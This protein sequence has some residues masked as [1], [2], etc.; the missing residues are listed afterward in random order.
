MTTPWSFSFDSLGTRS[1]PRRSANR[2]TSISWHDFQRLRWLVSSVDAVLF[3]NVHSKFTA[4]ALG[5]NAGRDAFHFVFKRRYRYILRDSTCLE[6]DTKECSCLICDSSGCRTSCVGVQ[7][8]TPKISPNTETF[9]HSRVFFVTWV[10][11]ALCQIMYSLSACSDGTT[12]AAPRSFHQNRPP[13]RTL[14]LT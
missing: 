3:S 8:C 13:A 7:P 12:S 4:S 1:H 10:V 2:P 6:K 5:C 11:P 9:L 14:S